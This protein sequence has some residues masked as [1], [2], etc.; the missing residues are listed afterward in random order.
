MTSAVVGD[1]DLLAG[2]DLTYIM[3]FKSDRTHAVSVSNDEEGLVCVDTSCEW[4]GT[5]AFTATTL[6]TLEPSHPDPDERGKD[7][8]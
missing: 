2:T 3:T 6:T 5:Y 4:D 8:S 1:E 7:T